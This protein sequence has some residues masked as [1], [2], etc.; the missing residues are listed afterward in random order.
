MSDCLIIGGGIIGMLTA[1]ELSQAGMRITLIERRETGRESSWAGGGIVS[2]LYPWRYADAVTALATWSQQRYPALAAALHQESGIDPEYQRSGLL[3]L[4]VEDKTQA[5]SWGKRHAIALHSCTADEA[6]SYDTGLKTGGRGGIWM[7]E[8]AQVRNPR[9][10]KA[11]RLAID[12]NINILEEHE[13]TELISHNGKIQG[14]R[15]GTTKIESERVIICAGAWSQKL[16]AETAIPPA[17][18][19]VK[20]QMILLKTNPGRVNRILLHNQ[21]YLIP[22]LDGRVLVGST[23]EHKGFDKTTTTE[24]Q[25]ELRQFACD[26]YPALADAPVEHHWAGLRPGSPQGIPFIGP[27]PGVEGLYLNAGHYR[28]G[29]VL[30][31]A[32]ARLMADLVLQREPSLDPAPYAL[33]AARE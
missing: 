30:G 32:S 20:G 22:R 24:T 19:P 2:P 16:L 26:H 7:P 1:H 27:V 29:V 28:N 9:L 31:P 11:A 25:K 8:V 23:L 3:V 17:I 18:E 21:R 6:V 15:V 4:E 14:V 12:H 13:I 10:V 5:L 33:D